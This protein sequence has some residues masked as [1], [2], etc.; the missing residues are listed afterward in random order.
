MST[1]FHENVVRRVEGA[2]ETQQLATDAPTR[3]QTV[4]S[5]AALRQKKRA[6]EK[7]VSSFLP[8]FASLAR[9]RL[10]A[11]VA[12][13]VAVGSGVLVRSSVLRLPSSSTTATKTSSSSEFVRPDPLARAALLPVQSS[14]QSCARAPCCGFSGKT[15]PGRHSGDQVRIDESV[16]EEEDVHRVAGNDDEITNGKRGME[17]WGETVGETWGECWGKLGKNMGRK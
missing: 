14:C 17:T 12:V 13:I 9:L 16:D 6:K 15:F 7:A 4:N 10:V 3:R 11:L 2:S 1:E 8:S 5:A